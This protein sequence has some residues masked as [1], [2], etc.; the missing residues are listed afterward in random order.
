M[1]ADPFLD[2]DSRSFYPHWDTAAD[3]C[4]AILRTEAGR[5]P[6]D[7]QLQDLVGELS[8]LSEDFRRRWSSHEVR[9]HGAGSKQFHHCVVGDLDLAYESV[10]MISDPGLTL[11]IY[12]AERLWKHNRKAAILMLIGVNVG[13]A[14]VVSHNFALAAKAPGTR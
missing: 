8:T 14:A 12:A 3:V 4:V 6:H 5:D 10:D 2:E 11:T 13:Y 1:S 7:R 9:L